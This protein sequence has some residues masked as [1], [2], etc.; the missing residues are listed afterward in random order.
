MKILL[1]ALFFSLSACSA[2]PYATKPVAAETAPLNDD[3]YVVSHG[4]HTGII[5]PA[6]LVQARIGELST[7]FKH[8]KYLEFGWGDKGF[9]QADEITSSLTLQAIFWSTE[10]IMHVVAVPDQPKLYFSNSQVEKICLNGSEYIALVKFIESS[11]YK[12][13]QGEVVATFQGLYGNSQFYKSVGDYSLM[14]TCNTWTARALKS[15]GMEI[16]T[17][18][19]LTA[20]SVMDFTVENNQTQLAGSCRD[21]R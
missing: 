11:F 17:R 14:N 3:I 12:N 10:S 15:A 13:D 18:F 8:A 1:P 9:Y 4:W 6:T 21:I 2:L 7:R 19:K 5:I 16:S 20:N